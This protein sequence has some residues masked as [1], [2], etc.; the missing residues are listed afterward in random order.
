MGVARLGACF[1]ARRMGGGYYSPS[2]ENEE[3][4]MKLAIA[5]LASLMLGNT[6]LAVEK[7]MEGKAPAK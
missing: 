4:T 6:A 2:L 3:E 5:L 1:I 7:G